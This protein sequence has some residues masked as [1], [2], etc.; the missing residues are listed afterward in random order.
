MSE[1]ILPEGGTRFEVTTT[2]GLTLAA[3]SYGD[4]EKPT[5]VLVHG[6]P[7]SSCVWDRVV[8]ILARDWHVVTYD[9]RGCGE[10]DV[11][12]KVSDYALPQLNADLKSLI[13]QISPDEPVHVV[14][15]DW[16]SIQSW[17][18]MMAEEFEGR[19]RSYT[20]ISGI[21]FD[22]VGEWL[23]KQFKGWKLRRAFG[24]LFR[25]WYFYMFH[26]PGLPQWAWKRRVAKM[27]H[28]LLEQNEGITDAHN[29]HQ[30]KD[31]LNGI[32]LYKA[33][34]FPR[35]LRPQVKPVHTPVQI[36]LLTDDP[37]VSPHLFS[38]H[39]KL[40]PDLWKREVASG[41]WLPLKD[42]ELTARYINEFVT[43]MEGGPQTPA[44]ARAHRL[45]KADPDNYIDGKQVLVTGAG[46]GIGRSAALK[47]AEEGADLILADINFDG[48]RDTAEEVRALGRRAL[49]Q[50]VDVSDPE[51][52]EH[53]ADWAE[54][55][56]G[57][58]DIVCNNA[59]I[60]MAGGMLETTRAAWDRI[61]KINLWSVID[62]SKI[63]AERMVRDRRPGAILNTA[64]AAGFTPMRIYPAYATTK[65]AVLMLSECQRAEFAEYDI[66]VSAICPGFADTGIAK[67]TEHIGVSVEEQE[68]RRA[69]ADAAYKKRAL[70]PDTVAAAM[71]Q[72]VKKN[73]PVVLVG[74]EARL[75]RFVQRVVPS[76]GRKLAKVNLNG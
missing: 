30:L 51:A 42:G 18:A 10:S 33:N 24:Q 36:I 55:E 68:A 8:P 12:A 7:D 38:D 9:V 22:H 31:G 17:N 28:K 73:K 41:H 5:I 15:H 40:C 2:D 76:L 13:D 16:G 19:I 43:Y 74:A 44:L 39:R 58:I 6:Y 61:I 34:F 67:A 52:I 14:G 60:G 53:L 21:S 49:V 32:N 26:I 46:S 62:G 54:A 57:P 72:G 59:G 4:T 23:R 27:W 45:G 37:Y 65:A 75:G 35:M 29:P 48:A 66:R 3:W 1:R 25:S 50:Q 11:P 64:S 47:F 69:Q 63:F 71:V 20:S 56:A 70:S